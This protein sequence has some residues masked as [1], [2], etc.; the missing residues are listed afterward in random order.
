MYG[1]QTTYSKKYMDK[2]LPTPISVEYV[3]SVQLRE[4]QK[5]E[6]DILRK[7]LEVCKKHNLSIWVNSGTLLGAIRHRGFIPWDDD[8]DLVMLRS[9]ERRVGKECHSVCRSRWSPYH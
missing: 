3:P 8:V 7:L 1:S 6:C 2:L 9:E 5:V 4:V